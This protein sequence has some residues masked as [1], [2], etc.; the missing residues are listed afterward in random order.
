[1]KRLFF[2]LS[3]TL[4]ST[5]AFAQFSDKVVESRYY[6]V[7]FQENEKEAALIAQKLDAY[8]DFYNNYFHFDTSAMKNRLKVKILGSKAAYID[9]VSTATAISEPVSSFLFI[10]YKDASKS[11]LI[12]YR[13]DNVEFEDTLSHYSFIQFFRN[14][15]TNPPLWLEKGFAVYFGKSFYSPSKNAIVYKENLTWLNTLKSFLDSETPSLID[16][17]TL[18]A[19]SNEDVIKNSDLFYAQSWGLVKFLIENQQAVYNRVIWDSINKLKPTAT[20]EENEQN[21]KQA[22][23]WLDAARFS[24]DFYEYITALKTFPQLVD[25]GIALY[26]KE[27]YSDAKIALIK[28][29]AMEDKNYIPYYYLGLIHYNTED[30]AMADFYYNSAIQMNGDKAICYYALGVN[31]FA[32]QNYEKSIRC[33]KTA[34]AYSAEYKERSDKIIDN[35]RTILRLQNRTMD[36]DAIQ[37]YP[38]TEAAEEEEIV[39]H[40]DITVTTIETEKETAEEPAKTTVTAEEL[41]VKTASDSDAETV[42]VAPKKEP[43]NETASAPDAVES[44]PDPADEEIEQLRL[45]KDTGEYMSVN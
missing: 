1:M 22:F 18:F 13:K 40:P 9:Y 20:K 17:N 7:Y 39:I 28:A 30:Y 21:A 37:P 24:K 5:A 44:R 43:G 23:A 3:V 25:S 41:P 4:L 15:I 26:E 38:E 11:E 35:I 31:A 16:L 32:E 33:L 12:G 19:M 14:F 8:F 45:N 2:I 10:Q 27:A 42:T 36:I 29:I 34:V 6:Q